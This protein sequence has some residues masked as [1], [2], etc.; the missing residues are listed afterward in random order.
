[1]IKIDIVKRENFTGDLPTY[2]TSGSSGFDFRAMVN[3]SVIVH[4]GE[5]VLIPTGL[6]FAIPEGYELQVRPRSG[7]ALKN[8]ITLVNSPGTID[9]DY[10]G[11][12]SIILINHS[13]DSFV[14]EHG[15]RIAQGIIMKVEKA[16]W[17]LKDSLSD[18]NRGAG[19]FGST[20]HD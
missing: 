6:S 4:S 13:Q 12:V 20:G 14:I 15:M 16:D 19:G 3:E 17:V 1:M 7:L 10:R 18:S 11:E 5:R 2:A 9:S 8:G